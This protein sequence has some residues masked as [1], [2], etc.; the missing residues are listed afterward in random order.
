MWKFDKFGKIA[1][2]V[3]DIL[4]II[5][6]LFIIAAL[7]NICTRNHRYARLLKSDHSWD[8]LTLVLDEIENNYVD[9]V[10]SRSLIE[11]SLPSI[12]GSLD[13]HSIYL[14]PK[15]LKDAEESLDGN[16]EGI[17]IQFNVPN[18]T[19][20]VINVIKGGPSDRAGLLSGD[21]IVKVNGENIAG[22]KMNQDSIVHKLKGPKGTRVNVEIK[23]LNLKESLN[24][25][26]TRDKI[27]A[28]S[29]DAAIMVADTIG[30]IKLSKFTKETYSDFS[31]GI[32]KLKKAGMRELMLDLRDNPGG[33]LDQALKVSNEFLPKGALIVYL[34]G[35]HRKRE[36]FHADGKGLCINVK[37]DV[38]I[39]ENS[40]S[41]SEIVA[42]AI[43][44]NDR[45]TIYG[46]RSFG[47]GLVQEPI[48]FSDKSGIRLTVARFYTP[49]GRCIQ[50]PYTSDYAYDILERYNDGELTSADSIKVN[51]SLAYKTAGG[52]TVYGGGG[53]IPDVFVPI[54]T[55]GSKDYLYKVNRKSLQ[56]K[57][58]DK[59]ADKYGQELRRIK[60]FAQLDG[61]LNTIDIADDFLA[62]SK[63][64]GIVPSSVEWERSSGI[65]TTQVKGLLGR[66]TVL[67]DNAF[68]PYML[69]IDNVA[70]KILKR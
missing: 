34:K 19:A 22:V 50:K 48:Y 40:A 52:R 3:I 35:L 51:D 58:S 6:L 70:Q 18:D 4:L 39:N 17:G 65:I 46:R 23:R 38:L 62:Y 63:K 45:G 57:Y 31:R 36:D 44:D 33:Y 28:K 26:I 15:E 1:R 61:L 64:N 8:K 43:Q 11:K 12:M 25:K 49:S 69:R 55:I 5:L 9:S 56:V 59:L 21:R 27:S 47:K 60:N 32:E 68:Y 16:F 54:D 20:V 30:Y 2:S 29:V 7:A 42:G 67:E 37:L 13:P 53:I 14:P 24:F 10:S 66:F 41:S